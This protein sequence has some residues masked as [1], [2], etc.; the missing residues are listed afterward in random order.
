MKCWLSRA[1]VSM[2]RACSLGLFVMLC[3]SFGNSG[4]KLDWKYLEDNVTFREKYS[5]VAETYLLYPTFKESVKK[6]NGK[7]AYLK[8][9]IIESDPS[10][11]LY[12]LSRYPMAQ[13]YFCGGGSPASIVEVQLQKKSKRYKTDQ[14]VTVSGYFYT[15]AKDIDHC[16]YILKQAVV[17]VH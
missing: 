10:I 8:G 17:T 15:N 1:G 3:C 7:Q 12:V 4:H 14:V 11:G 9:Y 2:R 16:N 5:P 13:C 6:L